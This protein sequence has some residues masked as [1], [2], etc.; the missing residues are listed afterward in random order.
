MTVKLLDELDVAILRRLNTDA[1]KSFRDIARELR[2]SISEL[3]NPTAA[4]RS[5]RLA[6]LMGEAEK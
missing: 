4:Q 5:R 6:W 3:P 2:V 1:R